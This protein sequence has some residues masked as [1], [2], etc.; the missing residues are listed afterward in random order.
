MSDTI[1][2]P[3]GSALAIIETMTAVDKAKAVVVA[4]ARGDIPAVEIKY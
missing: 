2:Q 1:E 3:T 4:V